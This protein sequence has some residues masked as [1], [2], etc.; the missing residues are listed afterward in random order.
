MST[1]SSSTFPVSASPVVTR[2]RAGRVALW[3]TQLAV[4]GMFF[5]AGS[6]KLAGAPEMI[7]LFEAI[8]IGQWF[9][10]ATGA[11]EVAAAVA[12]LVPSLAVFGALLLVPTMIG[13]IAAHLFIVGGSVAIPVVLLIASLAIVWARREQLY[14]LLP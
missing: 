2:H 3:I 13:A 12:L 10:Y 14:A 4:A 9:R 7:G 6:S 11:I 8:G 1:S 5:L